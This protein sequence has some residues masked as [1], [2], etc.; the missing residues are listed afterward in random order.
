MADRRPSIGKPAPFAARM[1]EEGIGPTEGLRQMNKAGAGIR[2]QDWYRVYGQVEAAIEGR[3]AA[4]T[5]PLDRVPGAEI[6]TPWAT[7]AKGFYYQVEHQVWDPELGAMSTRQGT[8]FSRTPITGGQALDAANEDFM[9]QVGEFG[10]S[11]VEW[12][13]SIITGFYESQG[14]Q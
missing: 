13:G 9:E 11:P 14:G 4:A 1:I 3:E 2:S 6:W 7:Q 8:V 5:F 12:Q 10:Y